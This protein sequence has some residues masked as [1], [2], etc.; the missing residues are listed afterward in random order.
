MKTHKHIFFDCDGVIANFI[1]G[2]R[3]A[4]EL[5]HGW[6][7]DRWDIHKQLG[8]S[9][10]ALVKKIRETTGF[11]CDLP[12]HDDGM[13]LWWWLKNLCYWTDTPLTIC[14]TPMSGD[15]IRFLSQRQLWIEAYMYDSDETLAIIYCKQK[16]LLA[17]H[18]RLLID[19]SKAN[20][21]AF[22]KAG[23]ETILIPRPWNGDNPIVMD[24]NTLDEIM[25]KISRFILDG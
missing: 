16:Q 13:R 8:I 1:E 22:E 23:G 19:D 3:V 12:F 25:A 15:E 24:E 7:A 17:G 4:L 21:D 20:T 14:T 18:G 5:P 11:W 2:L 9:R 6:V 10:E